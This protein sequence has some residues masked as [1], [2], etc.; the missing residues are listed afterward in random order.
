MRWVGDHK[1]GVGSSFTKKHNTIKL[2]Y[3]EFTNEAQLA[4]ARETQ[5]KSRLRKRNEGLIKSTYPEW[6]DLFGEFMI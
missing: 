3:Y 5:I 2:V 1:S 6:K 4:I